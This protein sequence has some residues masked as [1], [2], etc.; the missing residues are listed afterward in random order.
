MKEL[1]DR[2]ISSHKALYDV[3]HHAAATKIALIE[4][5]VTL[6]HPGIA[7]EMKMTEGNAMSLEVV[8]PGLGRDKSRQLSLEIQDYLQK[9]LNETNR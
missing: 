7:C 1:E 5:Y 3:A 2:F 4:A 9:L 8:F 6:H